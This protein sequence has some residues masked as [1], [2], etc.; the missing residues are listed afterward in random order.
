MFVMLSYSEPQCRTIRGGISDLSQ[1]VAIIYLLHLVGGACL[2]QR[3]KEV[4]I[5]ILGEI[6]GI[7]IMVM[8]MVMVMVMEGKDVAMP[9]PHALACGGIIVERDTDVVAGDG[10]RFPRVRLK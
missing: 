4:S 1:P 5:D 3:L 2:R 10:D 8:D 9:L 6:G 7:I